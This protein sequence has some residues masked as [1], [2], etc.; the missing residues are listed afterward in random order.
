MRVRIYSIEIENMS[1]LRYHDEKYTE[2]GHSNGATQVIFLIQLLGNEIELV[3]A[4]GGGH[5]LPA[6]RT[7][8]R[9]RSLGNDAL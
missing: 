5:K 9:A 7:R 1:T 3:V 4:A 6:K 2:L 8:T